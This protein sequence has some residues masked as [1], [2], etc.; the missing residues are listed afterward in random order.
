MK[1][2]LTD[3]IIC[4]ENSSVVTIGNSII[5]ICNNKGLTEIY[6]VEKKEWTQSDKIELP[7]SHYQ[8][9]CVK[10]IHFLH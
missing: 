5:V 2:S 6:D 7:K 1:P 3:N 4:F 9:C 10:S 8:F